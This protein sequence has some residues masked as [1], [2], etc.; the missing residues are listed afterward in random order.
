MVEATCEKYP[1]FASN[2]EC[3]DATIFLIIPELLLLSHLDNNDK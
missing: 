2:V 3:R 1:I